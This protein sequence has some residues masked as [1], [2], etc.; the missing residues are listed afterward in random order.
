MKIFQHGSIAFSFDATH[1]LLHQVFVPIRAYYVLTRWL[2]G[3]SYN[4]FETEMKDGLHPITA[5]LI[6]HKE[7]IRLL[8]KIVPRILPVTSCIS[9][10]YVAQRLCSSYTKLHR[11][12]L[13]IKRKMNKYWFYFKK[14]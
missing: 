3:N 10:L 13:Q 12:W 9:V 7:F 2:F 14:I 4:P 6:K 8:C 5:F 11:C 1:E